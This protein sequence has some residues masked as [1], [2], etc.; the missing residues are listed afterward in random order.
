MKHKIVIVGAGL[1]GTLLAIMLKRKKHEVFLF[2]KRSDIREQS[3][4]DGRSINL[5][6]TSRG[7]KALESVGLKEK[8]LDLSV[9]VYGRM[10]HSL[11]GKLAYQPYGRDDE[12]N[13][14]VSRKELNKLLL[15]SAS[16]EG[17]SLFFSHELR[18]IKNHRLFFSSSKGEVS[19]HGDIVFGADGAGS[20]VRKTGGFQAETSFLGT[21]YKELLMPAIKKN[22]QMKKNALHIWP[23][24]THML[25]GLANPDGTFTMTLYLPEKGSVSFETIKSKEDI[26]CFFENDFADIIPLMPKFIQDFQKNPDSPLG[27]VRCPY[28]VKNHVALIGDAAHA[29]VPF[30][31]QGMNAGFEDCSCIN[32]LLEQTDDWNKILLKY[33]SNRRPNGNAIADMAIENYKEMREKVG[34]TR[35]LLRKKIEARLEKAFPKNY[36]SRYGIVAYTLIPYLHAQKIGMIQSKIIDDLSM[37]ISSPEELDMGKARESIEKTLTPYLKKYEIQF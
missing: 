6:I 24:R 36:R 13:Y 28:W 30:F 35:F 26:Q 34:D 20:C 12:C 37:D 4:D 33:D 5:V 18:A 7:I 21:N 16:S 19:I 15:H 11:E 14:S 9:P 23:R 22:H 2:E 31:G 10:M 25:M 1:V 27:T 32:E 17:V 3:K 8:V 29:I